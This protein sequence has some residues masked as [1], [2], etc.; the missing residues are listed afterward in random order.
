MSLTVTGNGVCGLAIELAE[1]GQVRTS[2]GVRGKVSNSGVG[3]SDPALL[4]LAVGLGVVQV[5]LD[6]VL[7]EA[8]STAR[9]ATRAVDELASGNAN[10][11]ANQTGPGFRRA[12]GVEEM[13]LALLGKLGVLGVASQVREASPL[14]NEGAHLGKVGSG[15]AALAGSRVEGQVTIRDTTGGV[16]GDGKRVSKAGSLLQKRIN[17]L[18]VVGKTL[19]GALEKIVAY[20]A[21]S[22]V[23]LECH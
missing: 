20:I 4:V 11:G 2:A 16:E 6:E 7:V 19:V 15:G 12:L 18:G 10:V 14:K 21:V 3:G 13:V 9:P 8:V 22:D 1:E 23:C 17:L 5:H